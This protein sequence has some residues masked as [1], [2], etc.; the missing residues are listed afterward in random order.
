MMRSVILLAVGAFLAACG[1]EEPAQPVSAPSFNVDAA[2]VS[3]SGVSSGAMMA[4]QFHV[5]HSSLV[6]GAALLA[7]GPFYCA[8]G[9]LARGLGV[10]VKGGDPGLDALLA[11]TRTAAAEGR[12]DDPANL[13]DDPVWLFHGS[14][15]AAVHLDST[16]GARDFYSAFGSRIA[17]VVEDVPATHGFP[18]VDTGVA[19]DAL[20]PPYLNACDYDAAG[21][22]LTALHGDLAA[23]DEPAGEFVEIP[24][25]GAAD[26]TM[27]PNAVAYIPEACANGEACGVHVAF[28][29][30]QQST[31]LIGDAFVKGAGYNEWAE[32]NR[33]I[34]LYPQVDSSKVMPLNPLGCWDWWGYTDENYATKGG[35]QIAVVKATLDSL[36]GKT[37]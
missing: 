19:C 31:A 9:E 29:G 14:K 4:T 33:L 15:D 10:C 5:A 35:A 17:A 21:E 7:G 32:G 25:P 30:C 6:G 18:T 16:H 27:L 28:H 1:G 26:A 37:L 20:E 12:I 13:Q 2:R 3:V 23:R 24:Q 36:A 11:Y 8:S 34:V 22:L